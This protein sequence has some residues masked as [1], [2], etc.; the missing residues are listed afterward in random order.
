MAVHRVVV[1]DDDDMM[2]SA[3]VDVL[4]ADH[5]FQ[6]VAA[7]ATG[8]GLPDVVAR[9]QAD[10]VLLDVRMEEGGPDAARRLTSAPEGGPV[11]IAVS[12]EVGTVRVLE[13]LRAGA[14]GYLAKGRLGGSLPDLVAR[15]AQGEVLLAVPTASAAVR[16]LLASDR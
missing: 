2:R 9:H 3:L 13:M 12:A 15:C 11:V 16:H 6:V 5:R 10:V 14:T 4:R 1:A 8:R 7:V